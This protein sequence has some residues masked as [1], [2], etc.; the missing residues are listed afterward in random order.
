MV[1][2]TACPLCG[3]AAKFQGLD[4]GRRRL[5]LCEAC[6][7]FVITDT[8]MV[9]MAGA[10]QLWRDQY[11]AKTKKAPL[12]QIMVITASTENPSDGAATK[13][14]SATYVVRGE[15]LGEH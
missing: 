13:T 4:Y 11:A 5:V 8:A 6:T 1:F 9:R 2:D 10:P 3:H 15:A 12:R 14:L 7:D